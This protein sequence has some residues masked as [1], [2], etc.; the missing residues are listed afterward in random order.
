MAL[1]L[2]EYKPTTQNQRVLSFGTADINEDT[3]YIYRLE[4]ANSPSEMEEMIW[5]AY[6][7]VF[8]EQE[9]LKFNRQIGLETQLKNRSI[10]VKDFIRGLAKSERFYQLV[11]TPNNNYRLVE[12]CLKRLLGRSPYNEDE[13]IAWSIV[14]AS[15][16][17]GGF[18]DALLDSDEYQQ[19]FGDYTVPYQR[20]RLTTDRPFSFTPRYGADYRDRAGI[21]RPGGYATNW[22]RKSNPN[23]D[24][25]AILAVLLVFSA[26]LTFLFILNWLGYQL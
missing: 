13:K 1:P 6:R 12:M 25:M 11:V 23:Y 2:L 16:G 20:K 9:I 26:G 5:A 19:A 15:K 7:Q 21:L 22:Y 17:W 3:P 18:V 24:G 4:N 8:N 14:I 10:T